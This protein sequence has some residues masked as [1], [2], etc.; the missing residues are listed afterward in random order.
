[1]VSADVLQRNWNEVQGK[2]RQRWGQL[3]E[4]QLRSFEGTVDELVATIQRSTGESAEAIEHYLDQVAVGTTSRLGK[5]TE[6]ARHAVDRMTE[7][8]RHYAHSTVESMR[9]R[10]T[11]TQET[12]R[13]NPTR[14][15]AAA[16]GVGIVVGLMVGVAMRSR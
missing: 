12:I 7:T 16:F 9:D 14:S 8:G 10:Y 6:S 1:M 11:G 13:H 2:L 4:G 3:D 15:V 5:A